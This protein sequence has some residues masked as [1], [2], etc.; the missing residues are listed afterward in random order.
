LAEKSN[1]YFLPFCLIFF[2]VFT[3]ALNPARSIVTQDDGVYSQFAIQLSQGQWEVHPLNVAGVWPQVLSSAFVLQLFPQM[4][5]LVVLNMFT[6]SLFLLLIL[7]VSTKLSGD[8]FFWLSFFFFPVW[9]QYGASFLTDIYTAIL[10]WL[11]MLNVFKEKSSL[12]SNIVIYF[13]TVF[14]IL[15]YQVFFFFPF[16]WGL[17]DFFKNKKNIKIWSQALGS[18]TALVILNVLPKSDLQSYGLSLYFERVFLH[19]PFYELFQTSLLAVQLTL[20]LGL[21]LLPIVYLDFIKK[22]FLKIL[23]GQLILATF[24]YFFARDIIASGV[25]FTNYLPRAIGILFLSFG[26]WP[27]YQVYNDLKGK[28]SSAVPSFA[29]ILLVIFFNAFRQVQDIRYSMILSLPIL[30]LVYAKRGSFQK[31]IGTHFLYTSLVIFVSLFVNTYNLETAQVRWDLANALENHGYGSYEISAGY[32][33]DLFA[34]EP[35]CTRMA[36]DKIA[37]S[38]LSENKMKE[39]FRE[40]ILLKV[41]RVYEDEGLPRFLIKPSQFMGR[42]IHLTQN[43]REGQDQKPIFKKSYKVFGLVNAVSVIATGDFQEP[44]CLKSFP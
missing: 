34:L 21:F 6:W 30:W 24:L 19:H 3:V 12:Y 41:P 13:L 7:L 1:Q 17:F 33:R 39:L 5:S 44:W 31:S 23:L 43:R 20:G 22:F 42:K 37:T 15:Q 36:I 25:L 40:R 16:S 2:L 28:F 9:V 18:V 14:L 26:V 32:G 27:L 10:F 4:S 38:G 8:L 11:L 29:G 35:E